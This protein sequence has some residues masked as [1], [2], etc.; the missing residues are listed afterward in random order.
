[1]LVARKLFVPMLAAVALIAT[2]AP[3]LAVDERFEGRYYATWNETEGIC[4]DLAGA[5]KIRYLSE[6]RRRYNPAGPDNTV[7]LR[8]RAE[9]TLPWQWIGTDGGITLR[10]RAGTDSARGL[11]FEAECTWRVI[12]GRSDKPSD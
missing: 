2:A 8:Y 7:V 10:Y 1:M 6:T 3:G 12:L 11:A 5:V 4:G 9:E